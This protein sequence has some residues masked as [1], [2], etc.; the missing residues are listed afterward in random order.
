[1]RNTGQ[2]STILG[3][4][5]QCWAISDILRKCWIVSFIANLNQSVC[6]WYSQ[7]IFTFWPILQNFQW[8]LTIFVNTA[9]SWR[10]SDYTIHYVTIP[11]INYPFYPDL[12][13]YKLFVWPTYLRTYTNNGTSFGSL[14]INKQA[15]IE[16][17]FNF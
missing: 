4:I 9:K 8:Y 1:M 7:E 3:K 2:Y 10:I 5:V 12:T 15:G 13:I 17:Y 16:L 11:Q 14:E 6:F